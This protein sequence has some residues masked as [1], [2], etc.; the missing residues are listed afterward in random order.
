VALC[1]WLA[2]AGCRSPQNSVGELEVPP[3]PTPAAGSAAG[4]RYDAG[5]DTEPVRIVYPATPDSFVRLAEEVG[6]SIVALRSTG[7]VVGGPA[8]AFPGVDDDRALGTGF[9]IDRDGHLL[10]SDNL[11]ARAPELRAIIGGKEVVAE[12]IGRDPKL[13]VALLKIDPP[14]GLRPLPLGDSDTVRIG[15]WVA[16]FGNPFG[17]GAT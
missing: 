15:E 13:G 3:D 2:A 1:A 4:A 6:P 12:V 16:V 17:A 9:V 10:T 14:R 8:D 11:I 7:R 5:T